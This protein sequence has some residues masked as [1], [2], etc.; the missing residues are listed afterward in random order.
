MSN[1]S[2][3]ALRHW[4]GARGSIV[5][6]WAEQKVVREIMVFLHSYDVGTGRAQRGRGSSTTIAKFCSTYVGPLGFALAGLR[7]APL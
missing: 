4:P 7:R 6:A 2:E 5:A 1:A 3:A